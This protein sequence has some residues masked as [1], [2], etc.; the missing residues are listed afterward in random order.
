MGFALRRFLA[1]ANQK[2]EHK[3]DVSIAFLPPPSASGLACWQEMENVT[4]FFVLI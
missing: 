2:V 1:L 3:R 4:V